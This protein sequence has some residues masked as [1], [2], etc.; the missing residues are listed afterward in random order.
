MRDLKFRFFSQREP[1]K[2]WS[3]C[4]KT[5]E[6]IEDADSWQGSSP[7]RRIAVCQFTGLKDCKGKDVFEGDIV[8]LNGNMTAD[9][10][11][12]MLPNGWIFDEKDKYQVVWGDKFAAW[13]LKMAVEANDAYN[14]KYMN[15]A[16][17]LLLHGDC[18]V[19]GNVHEHPELLKN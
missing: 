4:E 13:E 8:S 15:H 17:S 11:L 7:W 9:D 12:G 19:I 1:D 16:R 3:I 2:K 5:L 14:A 18:E 6:E 10:S